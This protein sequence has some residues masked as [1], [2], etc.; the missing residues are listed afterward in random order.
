MQLPIIA[1]NAGGVPE[2]ITNG[3][4][5]LLIKPR[6]VTELT[7]AIHRVLSDSA[8]C[9]SLGRLA[10]EEALKRYDFDNCI[11]SL[12]ESVATL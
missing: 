3:K 12:L 5:G 11:D 2:I 1:T 8:L 6:D 4:T 10:R 9:L 7:L